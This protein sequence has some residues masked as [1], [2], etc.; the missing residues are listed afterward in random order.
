MKKFLFNILA[1]GICLLIVYR[2]LIF[3]RDTGPELE[4]D[5]RLEMIVKGE[6]QSDILIFGSSRGARSVVASQLSDS[7]NR[8]CYN[9]SY[10]GSD[11]TFHK[12]LLSAT[13]KQKENKKP[14]TV[15]LVVD[16]GDEFKRT[17]ALKFRYDRMFPLVKYKM[18]RDE[19]VSRNQ[20]KWG[21]T[22]V[23]VSHQLNKDFFYFE[24]KKF[25]KRDSVTCSGSMLIWDQKKIFNYVYKDKPY[26][27]SKKGEFKW[28]LKAFNEFVTLCKDNKIDL[29]IAIPP[30]FRVATNGFKERIEE[31]LDGY[32]MIYAFD[33]TI[34]EYKDDQYFFDNAHLLKKGAHIFTAELAEIL[35]H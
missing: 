15:V 27:Y 20:K 19:L 28:K 18:I 1:F 34:K 16:D 6:V 29:L 8:S 24:Q 12:Y 13:L 23:L 4:V 31:L 9:L 35:K 25:T 32:G 14:S 5:K 10:P 30:N 26:T 11:I 33:P 21:V 2:T 17:V 22:D 7:L 3:V